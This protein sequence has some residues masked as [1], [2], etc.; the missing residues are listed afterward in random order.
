MQHF[1]HEYNNKTYLNCT[2]IIN[3]HKDIW[4]FI[5]K[6]RIVIFMI[7]ITVTLTDIIFYFNSMIDIFCINNERINSNKLIPRTHYTSLKYRYFSNIDIFEL[8][9]HYISY[10]KLF[11]QISYRKD[12]LLKGV[13]NS[14][15][16]SRGSTWKRCGKKSLT[17]PTVLQGQQILTYKLTWQMNKHDLP[18]FLWI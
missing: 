11:W 16:T 17:L 9:R 14:C 13:P 3:D 6:Y 2:N 10:W 1:F 4:C 18:I 12:T 7:Y 8:S 5:Q 15:W